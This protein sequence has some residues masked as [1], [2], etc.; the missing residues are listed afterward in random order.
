MILPK[1][2]SWIDA[3]SYVKYGYVGA[4]LVELQDLEYTCPV[5]NATSNVTA[6]CVRTG[7][8]TIATLGLDY[9]SIGG[10]IGVL[11]GY[12][13]AL[14]IVGWLAVRWVTW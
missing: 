7:E 12:I 14:R 2:Y 5:V 10:C 6:A 11:F 8:Q 1:Y 4:S 3:L 9:I 13:I